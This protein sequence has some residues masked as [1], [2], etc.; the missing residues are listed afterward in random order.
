MFTI[1]DDL[2]IYV[3]RGDIV[4]LSI[5]AVNEGEPYTFK[6]GDVVRIKIFG[7]KDCETVVLQKD[8]PV[9]SASETV[10]IF[11]SEEDTKIGGV[12]NKHSDYWYEIELNPES[13]PQTIIGY[14][15]DGAKV[16]RLFPEGRDLTENNPVITPED[17]PIVDSELDLTSKRPVENQAIARAIERTNAEI[18]TVKSKLE[19][20][21]DGYA[22]C[23]YRKL[24]G[25]IEWI[26]PPMLNNVE[27]KTTERYLEKPVYTLTRKVDEI[28]A[29]SFYE[30]LIP[31]YSKI[32]LI[33]SASNISGLAITT[34]FASYGAPEGWIA[35]RVTNNTEN[36]V[37]NAIVTIKY[38]HND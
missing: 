23:Y 26:N 9:T 37:P 8:F 2:S 1:N 29:N 34:N 32:T 27:Y 14:D 11:L 10:E 4:H 7:K 22:G 17:I 6:M 24:N 12:I 36:V 38:I 20:E 16:F 18:T 15:D 33:Q 13:N 3:T 19:V 35:L 30:T 25:E 28:E 21:S 31:A 5:S